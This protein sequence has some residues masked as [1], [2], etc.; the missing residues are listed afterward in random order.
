[1]GERVSC[2]QTGK[3]FSTFAENRWLAEN[4]G[5]LVASKPLSL[6]PRQGPLPAAKL[7]VS[8]Q[9]IGDEMKTPKKEPKIEIKRGVPPLTSSRFDA[10]LACWHADH[11]GTRR[12]VN[13]DLKRMYKNDR[14][15]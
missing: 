5:I 10:F 2:Q 1:L 13:R 4:G 11:N 15:N 12:P 7:T 14:T 3:R 6:A 8:G 9:T